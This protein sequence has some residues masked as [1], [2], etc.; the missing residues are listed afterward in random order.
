VLDVFLA[1]EV[2]WRVRPRAAPCVIRHCPRCARPRAF[3]PSDKIR[4]NAQQRRLDVWLLYACPSCERTWKREVLSRVAPGEIA[5]D[6]YD[7]ILRNDPALA[8]RLACAPDPAL[9]FERTGDVVVERPPIAAPPLAIRLD[10]PL[11]VD[12]RLDRLLARELAW[13][14]A[15]LDAAVRDGR[16]VVTSH[17]A[18]ALRRPPRDGMRVRVLA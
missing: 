18:R 1:E 14:R 12:V 16:L 3:V 11:P 4:C 2:V 9:S 10:V 5:P 7:A 15:A 13:S 17:D 6:L 8:R